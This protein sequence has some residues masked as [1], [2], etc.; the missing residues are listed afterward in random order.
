MPSRQRAGIKHGLASIYRAGAL[1]LT[2]YENMVAENGDYMG[3]EINS[4]RM[5]WSMAGNMAMVHRVFMVCTLNT[6]EFASTVIP[7]NYGG[8]KTLFEF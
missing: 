5:R 3:T 1:F 8:T 4:D 7:E 6:T 2:N